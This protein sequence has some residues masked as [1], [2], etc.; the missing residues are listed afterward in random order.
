MIVVAEEANSRRGAAWEIPAHDYH[1]AWVSQ[2][3]PQAAEPITP[4]Y[5]VRVSEHNQIT[6]RGLYATIPRRVGALPGFREKAHGGALP[7]YR[8]RIIRRIVVHHDH[9]VTRRRHILQQKSIEAIAQ[10]SGCVEDRY[11]D[12]YLGQGSSTAVFTASF[13]PIRMW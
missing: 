13:W 7:R 2:A 1:H 12:G 9:F 4:W 10:R 5:A 11:D 3:R 6:G 8:H